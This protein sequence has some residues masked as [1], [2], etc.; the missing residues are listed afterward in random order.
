[1]DF[2]LCLKRTPDHFPNDTANPRA[3][4]SSINPGASAPGVAQTFGP[5]RSMMCNHGTDTDVNPT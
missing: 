3:M 1:M 4:H 5:C 2:P